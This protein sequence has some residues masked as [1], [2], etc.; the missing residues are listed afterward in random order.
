MESLVFNPVAKWSSF[1]WRISRLF[2]P[3]GQVTLGGQAAFEI[4]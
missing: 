3:G 1:M 4:H 2:N